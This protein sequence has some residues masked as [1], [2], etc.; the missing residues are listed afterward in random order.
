[1]PETQENV[2][3]SRSLDEDLIVP[4]SQN[5]VQTC[6]TQGKRVRFN[7]AEKDDQMVSV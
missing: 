7:V 5:C 6:G 4:D 2:S 3:H 1:M